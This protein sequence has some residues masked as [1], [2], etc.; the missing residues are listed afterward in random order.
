MRNCELTS[1]GG[2]LDTKGYGFGVPHS[3]SSSAIFIF[4]RRVP[5]RFS[6]PRHSE[7][8]DSQAAG[9]RCH[10]EVLQQMVE[11]GSESQMRP[12]RQTKGHRL[13]AGLCQHRR[14]FCHPRAR[15]A[16]LDDGGCDR[17][18]HQNTQPKGTTGTHTIPRRCE[19]CSP[20]RYPFARKW[21]DT[22][23]SP[24]S[25]SALRN[26]ERAYLSKMFRCSIHTILTTSRTNI[27][28]LVFEIDSK[29]ETYAHTRMATPS[30]SDEVDKR[31]HIDKY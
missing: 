6:V 19:R 17:I 26:D 3:T 1:I 12:G 2:L 28:S 8:Y 11:G 10:S 23:D 20:F 13:G 21:N 27:D 30:A 14:Y 16:P 24:S 31:K 22:F 7:R 29:R 5:C 25:T 4:D 15:L 9:R 18:Q